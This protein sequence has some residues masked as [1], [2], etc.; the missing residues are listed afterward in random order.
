[1]WG[2]ENDLGFID[3]KDNSYNYKYKQSENKSYFIKTDIGY[4]DIT[5]IDTLKFT[6][7]SINVQT[8]IIG[9]FN[10]IKSEDDIS[11][12][13]YRLYNA[14]F[15]RFPDKSG[16]QYWIDKNIS[17][18]NTYKQTANSF[19]ISKEFT[20]TYG[21]NSSNSEYITNLYSNVLSRNPDANGFEY[22][23]NQ[24]ERGLE[25]RSDLLIGFAE[26]DENKST[27]LGETNII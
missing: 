26:S 24:I 27:F 11:S 7:K 10:L 5:E 23:S 25:D 17:G 3:Y 13:I 15:S 2:R 22:W 12:K 19:L 6:D 4:E 9:I 14:A 1:M 20:S 16:L 21:V 18:E 8:D